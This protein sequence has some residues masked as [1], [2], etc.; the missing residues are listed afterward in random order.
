MYDNSD[1]HILYTPTEIIKHPQ[2][3]LV[4]LER[5]AIFTC[6]TNGGDITV[7][8]VNGDSE[9]PSEMAKD[10][11]TDREI[12]GDNT[13]LTLSI[14]AKAVYN[15]TT[16]QCVTGDIGGGV[17]E[18]EIVTLEIRGIIHVHFSMLES[19]PMFFQLAYFT[20]IDHVATSF[21]LKSRMN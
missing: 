21:I 11:G 3:T 7:W 19:S 13:L 18:S 16:I 4:D 20:T 1:I 10:V 8:R 14:T 9:I 12:V 2:N 17:V 15:G 5:A 6:E